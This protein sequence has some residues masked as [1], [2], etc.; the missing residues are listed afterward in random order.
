MLRNVRWAKMYVLVI[1][2]TNR[3]A[4]LFKKSTVVTA[5]A[6]QG[7]INFKYLRTNVCKR[8]SFD[9]FLLGFSQSIQ[10]VSTPIAMTEAMQSK[11]IN[12]ESWHFSQV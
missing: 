2:Q 5:N 6:M 1:L 3:Y 12:S 11:K 8:K 10:D 7:Y 9:F 4:I